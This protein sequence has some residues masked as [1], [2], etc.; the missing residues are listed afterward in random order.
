MLLFRPA[1]FDDFIE[2]KGQIGRDRGC[3]GGGIF[4]LYCY[5]AW[6]NESKM[7]LDFIMAASTYCSF[8]IAAR[9]YGMFVSHRSTSRVEWWCV[10][11]VVW[12]DF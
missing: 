1:L 8:R 11:R 4:H 10:C 5:V 3:E 12:A 2:G 9:R 6:C 7:G